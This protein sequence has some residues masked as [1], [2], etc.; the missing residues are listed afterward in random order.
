MNNNRIID[1]KEINDKDDHIIAIK[2]ILDFKISKKEISRLSY[3][4]NINNEND[5]NIKK[6]YLSFK[7][8]SFYFFLDY[9][10]N[11]IP[12]YDYP[13]NEFHSFSC[14]SNYYDLYCVLN[15]VNVYQKFIYKDK[16]EDRHYL[17]KKYNNKKKRRYI[18]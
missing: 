11:Y 9:I 4:K 8:K 7:M 10:K 12:H 15:R 18:F 17:K 16:K 14:Y 1:I 2:T 6:D 5:K 13:I 3:V